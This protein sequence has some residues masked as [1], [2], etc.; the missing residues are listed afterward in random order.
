MFFIAIVSP[1]ELEENGSIKDVVVMLE[2]DI[3][4]V[5]S[6]TTAFTLDVYT[7]DSSLAQDDQAPLLQYLL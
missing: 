7:T 1:V 4:Q 2:S 6:P 5:V 3:V